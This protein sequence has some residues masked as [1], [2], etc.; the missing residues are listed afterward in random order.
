[1]MAILL[2]PEAIL[3]A[4][5]S[6]SSG[7]LPHRL[8]NLCVFLEDAINVIKTLFYTSP[9]LDATRGDSD[10]RDNSESPVISSSGEETTTAR[11]S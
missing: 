7:G 6:Q 3:R 10:K 5:S 4:D 11:W 8:A 1:M 9:V 2:C